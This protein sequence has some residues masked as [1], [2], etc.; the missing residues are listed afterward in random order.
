MGLRDRDIT[1]AQIAE[2]LQSPGAW[3]L[4]RFIGETLSDLTHTAEIPNHTHSHTPL[5]CQLSEVEVRGR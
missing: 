5:V 4:L 3:T 2:R 1:D